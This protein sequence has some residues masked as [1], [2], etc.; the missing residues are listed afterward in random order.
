MNHL[1]SLLTLVISLG[2]LVLVYY[3][4][5]VF[6]VTYP[7]AYPSLFLWETFLAGVI[8]TL[9]MVAIYGFRGQPI[10]KS[11]SPV[12]F[13]FFVKFVIIQLLFQFSG[14]YKILFRY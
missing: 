1:L 5:E 3:S 10:T 2:L 14:L 11:N 12:F 6:D 8:P 13:F 7:M 4:I 9:F